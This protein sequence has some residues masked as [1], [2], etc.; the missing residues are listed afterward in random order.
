MSDIVSMQWTSPW[1]SEIWLW[2]QET[3]RRIQGTTPVC[4]E[5]RQLNVQT[6]IILHPYLYPPLIP[7]SH[8]GRVA[9]WL[10]RVPSDWA[11]DWDSNQTWVAKINGLDS[12]LDQDRTHSKQAI[13][14]N[15]LDSK[16]PIKLDKVKPQQEVAH[17]KES[18]WL[19]FCIHIILRIGTY[20]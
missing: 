18:A 4:P 6:I 17:Q 1:Y 2:K 8:L 11:G 19:L 9:N 20:L 15:S 3:E 13:W 12:Q 5:I 14:Q 10:H 16:T 7:R